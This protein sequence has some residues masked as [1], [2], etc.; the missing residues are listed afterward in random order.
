MTAARASRVAGLPARLESRE[1]AAMGRL[2]RRVRK[3]GFLRRLLF[4]WAVSDR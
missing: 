4:F 3:R 1:G 2:L